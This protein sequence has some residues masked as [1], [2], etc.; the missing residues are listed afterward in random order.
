[1]SKSRD[2][3]D[4]AVWR[5]KTLPE[6][7]AWLADLRAINLNPTT[8]FTAALRAR[9]AEAAGAFAA[10]GIR[11]A[12]ESALGIYM[13][14]WT[15]P[16]TGARVSVTWYDGAGAPIHGY[17]SPGGP[18]RTAPIVAPA[19]FGWPA[20]PPPPRQAFRV[21]RAFAERYATDLEAAL[22]ADEPEGTYNTP[23]EDI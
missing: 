23:A 6:L 7:E 2:T 20:D 4:P 13:L 9:R 1:M 8:S 16:A 21:L 19:R 17:Q 22:T 3:V 11:M 14:T 12:N 18:E 10:T 5:A 15:S